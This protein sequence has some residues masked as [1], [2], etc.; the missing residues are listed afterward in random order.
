MAHILMESEKTFDPATLEGFTILMVR[1]YGDT[2][3]ALAQKE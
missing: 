2:R 1:D 3:I